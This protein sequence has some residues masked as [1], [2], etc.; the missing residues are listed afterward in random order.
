MRDATIRPRGAFRVNGAAAAWL[1]AAAL[2]AIYV[3]STLPT[4]LYVVYRE[5]FHF[6]RITLTLVYAAYVAGSLGAMLV[7]GRDDWDGFQ[8][9]ERGN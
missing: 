4:P 9:D 5:A 6:G 2:A 7:F 1:V 3:L 8:G